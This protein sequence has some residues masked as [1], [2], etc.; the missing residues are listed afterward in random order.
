ML[1][2]FLMGSVLAL[3]GISCTVGLQTIHLKELDTAGI[4]IDT[5]DIFDTGDVPD[6]DTQDTDTQDTDTQDTQDS[7]TQDTGGT[8]TGNNGSALDADGDGYRVEDGD[9][10]DQD[11]TVYPLQMDYCDNID[12]DCDGVIDEE[13][14]GYEYEPNDTVAYY[15]D[16]YAAGD[17]VNIQGLIDTPTDI[18]MYEF[19]LEDG[20]LD[21]FGIEVL[22]HGIG[23][24]TDFVVEVWLIENDDGDTNELLFI[25]DDLANGGQEGGYW[26]GD[27]M[28]D[29][30]GTYQVWV[31]AN[32]GQDC[33]GEYEL[34]IW[35]SP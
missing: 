16:R 21:F 1:Q 25:S 3:V 4:G 11:P 10:N 8:D 9:C 15:L 30:Q 29:D 5:A 32:S 27:W 34:E 2:R 23:I 7:N 13:A 26:D 6:T 19:Y 22:L 35:M 24:N 31:Y 18:D 12:N 17:Y 28:V 14:L 20:W 33:S